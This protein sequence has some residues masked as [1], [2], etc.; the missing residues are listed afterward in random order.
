MIFMMMLCVLAATLSICLIFM[1]EHT[2]AQRDR[3]PILGL[4]TRQIAERAQ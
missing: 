4:N 3:A 1:L 2:H